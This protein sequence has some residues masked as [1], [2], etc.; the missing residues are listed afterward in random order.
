MTCS[1]DSLDP[2]GIAG[3]VQEH[4]RLLPELL[5]LVD[6]RILQLVER[7]ENDIGEFLADMPENLLSRIEFRTIRGQIE[8]MHALR[9]THFTTAMTAR[10]VEHDPDR[11]LSQLVAHMPQEDLQALAFHARQ[12]E[13][14]ACARGGFHR[15]I[16]PEPLVV[17]LYD[18]RRTFP[19]W[20]PPP[21]QPGN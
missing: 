13:K 3:E 1:F 12:Q 11:T 8:R 16:Q 9:P 20:T 14:D 21:T 17:V 4:R 10:T 5:E 6:E 19:Q 15:R 2:P 18:P 7:R